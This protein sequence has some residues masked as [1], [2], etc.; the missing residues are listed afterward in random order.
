MSLHAEL[1]A[2]KNKPTLSYVKTV[3]IMRRVHKHNYEE[4]IKQF[5]NKGW[6]IVCQTFNAIE[7]NDYTVLVEEVHN[8][9]TS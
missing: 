5:E 6:I 8:E 2:E 9:Q 3:C 7:D 4:Y 1:D